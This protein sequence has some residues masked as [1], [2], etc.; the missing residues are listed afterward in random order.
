MAAIVAAISPAMPAR[1]AAGPGSVFSVISPE[2][3]AAI[4]YHDPSRAGELAGP[5][6][7]TSAE[8][9][10]LGIAD[11]VLPELAADRVSCL[12]Q[13]VAGAL[14]IAQPGD[15]DRR[16]AKATRSFMSAGSARPVARH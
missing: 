7:L 11:G 12:R 10:G 4:L 5:L 6:R 8:L 3:A 2:G 14:G 16:T 15:R 13:A 1:S 9:I